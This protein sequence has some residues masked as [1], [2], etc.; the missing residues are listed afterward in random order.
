MRKYALL[1]ILLLGIVFLSGCINQ[2]P[3]TKGGKGLAISTFAPDFAEIRSGEPVTLSALITNAGEG[4]ATA[5]KAQLFGLNMGAAGEGKEWT[6]KSGSSTLTTQLL[7]KADLSLNLQGENYEFSWTVVSPGTLRVDNTYTANL[8]VYYKYKTYSTSILHFVSYDYLRSLTSEQF[9]AEKAK[10]GVTQSTSS[11]APVSVKVSG[12]NRPFIA[13]SDDASAPDTFSVQIDITNADSGNAFIAS[14]YPPVSSENLHKVNINIDTNLD[15]NCANTLG[16]AKSG[17]VTLTK[18]QSKTIFCTATV[19]KAK[20]DNARDYTVNVELDYGYY[21]DAS[22]KITVLKKE[23]IIT[24]TIIPTECTSSDQCQATDTDGGD[25]PLIK[26][27]CTNK[28]CTNSVCV[29]D[30][31]TSDG[32][33]GSALL[34]EYFPH[35]T[36]KNICDVKAYN[37][38]SYCI[39]IGL[40]SGTC[41]SGVCSCTPTT[42]TTTL[43]DCS[44]FGCTAWTN[45]LCGGGGCGENTMYQTRTCSPSG[46]VPEGRCSGSCTPAS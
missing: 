8:R 1:S 10:A 37:C 21:L 20:L 35:A 18:G 34:Y 15:L 32:C 46:C 25:N 24:A 11:A 31:S 44:S 28:V 36:Y 2:S 17:Q 29:N 3:V 43:L 9:N 26:G 40:V 4:D 38:N 5:V 23:G 16:S 42:T 27:T 6:L 22:T 14:T 39:S 30:Y 12:G 33:S 41:S 7:R 19:E 45:T 13:Y